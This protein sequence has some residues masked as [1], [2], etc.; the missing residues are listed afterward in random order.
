[1]RRSHI[2]VFLLSQ[3]DTLILNR[4]KRYGFSRCRA[5]TVIVEPTGEYFYCI[6]DQ[7]TQRPFDQGRIG[8]PTN[9]R[10]SLTVLLI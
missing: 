4:K 10:S 7:M 3:P 5:M 6:L 8:L 9:G 1:M 2:L